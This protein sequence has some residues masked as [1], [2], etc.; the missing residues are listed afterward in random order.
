VPSCLRDNKGTHSTTICSPLLTLGK[1]SEIRGLKKK[2]KERERE[3]NEKV[4]G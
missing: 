3:E 4:E 2:K 1:K